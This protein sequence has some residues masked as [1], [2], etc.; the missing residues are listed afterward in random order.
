MVV[1]AL[2]PAPFLEQ[3]LDG[4]ARQTRAPD[5]VVVVDDGSRPPLEVDRAGVRLLRRDER[6]GAPA[7]RN[8]ALAELDCE[9]I[10]FC[11][12]DD[13][14]AP[15]KLAEQLAVAADADVVVGRAEIVD[16]SGTADRRALAA[17]RPGPGPRAR[18]L[19]EPTRS[20][21]RRCSCAPTCCATA[22]GFDVDLPPAEDWDLW[23]R[24][25]RA[26]ARFA[27]A[28][29]AV[30]RYR[31]HPDGLTADV[32]ALARATLAVHRRHADLVDPATARRVQQR[33]L[34]ALQD[35]LISRADWPGAQRRAGRGTRRS[36]PSP[37]GRSARRARRRARPP[38][39]LG[40]RAPY[41]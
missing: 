5:A 2:R 8:A 11:D 37:L 1:P 32:A 10:A 22:G 3:T 34:L 21:P 36:A 27:V 23:L 24:L 29:A 28:E 40:R 20:S 38:R 14:W 31:R 7:A 18:L 35:G 17:A 33:D 6:G 41:R 12:A 30:V 19:Y 4:L 13:V 9:W 39:A 16:A 15:D 26:G 25:A